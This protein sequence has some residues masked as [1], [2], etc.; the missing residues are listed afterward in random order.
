MTPTT[1]SVDTKRV[2]GTQAITG[3]TIRMT[4]G[5]QAQLL[6]VSATGALVEAKQRLA[7]GTSVV[8]SIDGERPQRLQGSVVRSTVT[9]IHRDSTMTYQLAIAFSPDTKFDGLPEEPEPEAPSAAPA[10]VPV[11]SVS[12]V[13][14]LQNEW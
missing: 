4:P 11:E 3:G 5:G 12:S 10:A 1:P 7:T 9:A 2:P 14:V 6:N 13:V 8:M